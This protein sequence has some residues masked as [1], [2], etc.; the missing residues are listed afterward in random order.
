M[1]GSRKLCSRKPLRGGKR[2]T[3]MTIIHCA[4]AHDRLLRDCWTQHGRYECCLVTGP[5]VPA[6]ATSLRCPWESCWEY[7]RLGLARSKAAAPTPTI[8]LT[9]AMDNHCHAMTMARGPATLRL[10]HA[11]ACQHSVACAVRQSSAPKQQRA[12]A[13]ARFGRRGL[14]AASLLRYL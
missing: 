3:S 14:Q 6:C 10:H 9:P 1:K 8:C 5:C 4:Y 12:K 11:Y 2:P 7:Q 13:A